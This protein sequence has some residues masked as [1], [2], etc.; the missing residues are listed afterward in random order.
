[1]ATISSGNASS[2]MDLAAVL[3]HCQQPAMTDMMILLL[4]IGCEAEA[5]YLALMNKYTLA[6]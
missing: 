6:N 3:R 5:L 1:M 4:A 2:P